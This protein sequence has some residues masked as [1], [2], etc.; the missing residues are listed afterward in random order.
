MNTGGGY[1]RGHGH[2]GGPSA[3]GHGRGSGPSAGGGGRRGGGPTAGGPPAGGHG[4]GGGPPGG[5]GRG[6]GPTAG[7]PPAGGPPAGGPPAGGRGTGGGP[8]GGRGRGGAGLPARLRGGGHAGVQNLPVDWE[9]VHRH[10]QQM[11]TQEKERPSGTREVERRDFTPSQSDVH[12]LIAAIAK[13]EKQELAHVPSDRLT[14]KDEVHQPAYSPTR[15]DWRLSKVL[16]S[17]ANLC[18]SETNHEVIATALRVHNEAKS[19]EL[20]IAS[21]TN[22]KPSTV[23]HLQDMWKLLRKISTLSHKYYGLDSKKR[24]PPEGAPNADALSAEFQQ[25]C[26]EFSFGKLQK[27]INEKFSRF[28]AIR[29]DNMEESHPFQMV[30]KRVNAIEKNFTREEEPLTGKPDHG[31]ENSWGVLWACLVAAKIAIDKFLNAGGFRGEDMK[32]AQNFFEYESYLRKIESFANDI[33]VLLKAANSPQ[34]RHLFTFEFKIKDLPVQEGKAVTV[35]QTSRDWETVLENALLFRNSHK[36]EGQGN[37]LIDIEKIKEDTA[38]LA[39]EALK[40][41]LVVHCEVKILTHIFKTET[42]SGGTP[43]AYTYIGVSKL[44]CRGCQAFFNSFNDVHATH[45]TTKGSHSKSYW[46]WQFPP[47]FAKKNEVLSRTYQFIAKRWVESY[48]GYT[49]GR[50]SLAQDS[51]A[52]TISSWG[53]KNEEAIADTVPH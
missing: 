11:E 20:I 47:S 18:V 7:G 4:T 32:R 49:V 36:E 41:N 1:Q 26:L 46:P 15:E 3:G 27:R 2:G 44:S 48:G 40:R 33:Q 10:K 21:N 23:G 38:Y 22:I 53:V 39:S 24:T 37:Y 6:G 16:D 9:D 19:I 13:I 35:P 5:R 28:S 51:E 34:C 29:I 43:K 42:E 25:L 31:D 12:E 14:P 45:F 8:S 30:R 17:I 52:Q 50:A